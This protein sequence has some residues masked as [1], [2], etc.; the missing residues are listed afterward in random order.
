MPTLTTRMWF[1]VNALAAAIPRDG[2]T[3]LANRG[4][5]P[6]REGG[7]RCVAGAMPNG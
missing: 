3:P 7:G 6:H 4:A 5:P 1:P 2:G